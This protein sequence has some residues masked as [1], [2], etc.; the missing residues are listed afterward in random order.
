V[1]LLQQMT[2]Q[3]AFFFNEAARRDWQPADITSQVAPDGQAKSPI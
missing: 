1:T 2:R 3:P